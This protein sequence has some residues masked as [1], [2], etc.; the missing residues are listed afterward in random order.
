MIAIDELFYLIGVTICILSGLWATAVFGIFVLDKVTRFFR[1]SGAIIEFYIS[2][3][4]SNKVIK[5]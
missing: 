1:V 5:P 4:A 2:K 3:K